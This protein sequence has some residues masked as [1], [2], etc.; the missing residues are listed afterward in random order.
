MSNHAAVLES[1]D[2]AQSPQETQEMKLS[3]AGVAADNQAGAGQ[4]SQLREKYG[5]CDLT[6]NGL[7]SLLVVAKEIA[8]G[9]LDEVVNHPGRVLGNVAIGAAVG[10]GAALVAPEV[11]VGAALVGAGYAAYEV[12][13]NASDWWNSAKVVA[14]PTGKSE[15]EQKQAKETLNNIGGGAAD[16]V[17]GGLGGATAA[18]GTAVIKNGITQTIATVMEKAV[19]D[20][21][22]AFTRQPSPTLTVELTSPAARAAA[23][24]AVM[25]GANAANRE[26]QSW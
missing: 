5:N 15:A 23:A 7:P 11:A 8:S 14:D 12:Y 4:M 22:A 18:I 24:G 3:Q 25:T 17:A 20:V 21:A 1:A 2:I 6:D 19:I 10:V 26:I 9:A 13:Q 16:I